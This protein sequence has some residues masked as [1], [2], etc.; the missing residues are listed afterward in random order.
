MEE[1]TNQ[2]SKPKKDHSRTPIEATI[3]LT[4]SILL[5][6]MADFP[7]F[8]SGGRRKTYQ[9]RCFNRQMVLLGAIEMYNMDNKEMIRDYNPDTLD[10]LIK[11]KYIRAD[12]KDE[13]ECQFFSEG[14]L[15][16]DGYI[17]CLNHGSKYGNYEGKDVGASLTPKKDSKKKLTNEL[18]KWSLVFGSTL[19]YLLIRLW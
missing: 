9:D 1:D 18:I 14:D 3:I 17:Y 8:G 4:I 12:W 13:A 5:V 10:L 2:E 19:F 16:G 6:S 7:R 11:G 15:I